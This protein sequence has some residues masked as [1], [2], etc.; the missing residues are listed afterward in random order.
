MA[1]FSLR[2]PF[3]PI[4]AIKI[5]YNIGG[6][7]DIPAGH[8]LQGQYGESI[9]NG[10]LTAFT[11]VVGIANNFKS[12]L[13]DFMMLVPLAHFPEATAT[14]Y[15]TETNV[16][17]ARKQQ[18][19]ENIEGLFGDNNPVVNG[20][21]G[22][23]DNSKYYGN[24]YYETQKTFLKGKVAAT[25]E[26]MRATPFLDRDGSLFKIM[27]PTFSIVD[28][29]TKFRTEDVDE[30]LNKNELGDS[31]S[32][33]SYMKQGASKARFLS[34]LPKLISVANNP[35]IMTAH[36]GKIIAMD[37]RAAPIKKL[38]YL[39]N[40]DTMKGVTD[41]FLFFTTICWQCANAAPL[42]NDTTKSI[43]YPMDKDDTM[44]MDTDLNLVTVTLLRNKAGRSGLQMQ[45]LVSQQEGFLPSLSEFHYIKTNDRFGLGGN[46]QNY[47]LELCPDVAL[48]RTQVRRK[49]ATL[50][51]LRRAVQIT[52]EMSQM[53]MLWKD[54]DQYYCTAKEL[55]D[56]LIAQGYSWDVLLDTR[57]WWTFDN[58]QQEVQFLSTMDLLRMRVGLYIPYWMKEPPAKAIEL[59]NSKNEKPWTYTGPK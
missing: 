22:L 18:I 57:G 42:I 25:K 23:T 14:T 33:T 6:L 45:I 55:Y 27:V 37:A 35:F 17:E 43:E 7:F 20:R 30:M 13:T 59:Y 12:L 51:K 15:D 49:L 26:L 31:G 11:G 40:G 32:N 56:D 29:L 21:W 53:F 38:Q 2:S 1:G 28:S 10:G 58:D 44:K 3:T 16:S 5:A 19:A 4:P 24:E 52:S 46:L 39:K 54:I 34:D 36:I 48:S 41:D 50:P 47:F 9:L 8:Y